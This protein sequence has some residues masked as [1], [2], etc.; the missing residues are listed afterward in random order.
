MAQLFEVSKLLLCIFFYK[1]DSDLWKILKIS[2][3]VI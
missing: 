3:I 2:E 1:S